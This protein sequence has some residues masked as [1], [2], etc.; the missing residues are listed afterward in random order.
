MVYSVLYLAV[1]IVLHCIFDPNTAYCVFFLKTQI[2]CGN[3][4]GDY[5][6]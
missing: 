1:H 4:E 3:M 5:V 6:R 2:G